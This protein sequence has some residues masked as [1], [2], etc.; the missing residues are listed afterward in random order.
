MVFSPDGKFLTIAGTQGDIDLWDSATGQ[1]VRNLT[2]AMEWITCLPA[3]APDGRTLALALG[4]RDGSHCRIRLLEVATGKLRHEFPGHP[5]FINALVFSPDGR[6]L[7]SASKDT[8]ILLWDVAGRSK[9]G[10]WA[11]GPRISASGRCP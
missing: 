5:G 2:Q 11:V 3:Y 4:L 10:E 1:H 6:F 8:T 9:G 7:A